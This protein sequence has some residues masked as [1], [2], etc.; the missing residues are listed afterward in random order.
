MK[1]IIEICV[2]ID[3]AILGIAYPIIVDKISNI[4]DKYNSNY[5]SELFN[6][7]YPQR[8][9]KYLDISTFKFTL[10]FN[11][12][13][14]I[15]LIL[16]LPPLF[17]TNI[18]IIDNFIG[19]SAEILILLSTIILTIQFFIWLDKVM[20]FNGKPTTLLKKI[21]AKYNKFTNDDDIQKKYHLKTINEFSFFALNNLNNPDKHLQKTL[22]DFYY[23]EFKKSRTNYNSEIQGLEYPNELYEFV[24]DLCSSVVRKDNVQIPVLEHRAVSSWW[25]LG[26]SFD[27][28]PISEKTYNWL[29]RNIITISKKEKYIR[30]HW[31]TA[32]QY[33]SH[34]LRPIMED[35][36]WNAQEELITKNKDEVEKRRKERLVFLEFHYALGG[37]LLHKK[38]YKTIDYILNYT[39]SVPPSYELLPE[40]MT[41]IFYWFEEFRNEF[42]RDKPVD[43]KYYFPELD[44]Y[45]N[46]GKI[47]YR[48]SSYIVLLFIRQFSRNKHL[49]Y[50]NFTSLPE[51]PENI[52]ELNNW[53][54]GLSYFE[55]CLEDVTQNHELLSETNFSNIVKTK[56][57]EMFDFVYKLKEKIIE[58]IGAEKL[59]APLSKEKI[60]DFNEKTKNIIINAFKL[61]DNIFIPID[62]KSKKSDLKLTVAGINTL[63]SKSAFTDKDIPNLN[64]DTVLASQISNGNIKRYIPN[65]FLIARTRRYLLN[66]DN[67]IFGIEKLNININDYTIVGVNISDELS[68]KL[69]KY[70]TIL[71]NIPS[72]QNQIRNTLFILKTKDL[73]SIEH[74][75]LSEEEKEKFELKLIDEKLK[76]YTSVVELKS[77]ELK[78]KWKELTNPRDIEV[79]V[80]VTIAFLSLIIWKKDVDVVQI[81]IENR[82]KEQG[83]PT[84]INEITPF[85]DNNSR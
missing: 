72:T 22:V 11:I 71:A 57:T 84:D 13:L 70:K 21:I 43:I 50:Q 16:N 41:D 12:F 79:N 25:I 60:K 36:E 80:R 54:D 19:N 33:L 27:E 20:L 74:R 31:S 69:S 44:N 76:L 81:N 42:K 65:S 39:Q 18:S 17:K 82:Y 24:Y 48:I 8:R 61:Y 9:L 37:L 35:Y 78:E 46:S 40:T 64:F 5:L 73:P 83:I 3:I 14:F 26:E 53:Y 38:L 66:L 62:K 10:Y 85:E 30:S 29:W 51:L 59:N 75:D 63:F 47:T 4:G 15:F 6:K 45:G 55:K 58:K 77:K 49:T 56:K 28:I 7:E 68:N 67:I 34:R 23:F 2:A 1:Y 52:L 32:H